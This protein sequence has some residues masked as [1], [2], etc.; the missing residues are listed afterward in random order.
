ML[1]ACARYAHADPRFEASGFVGVDYFS[2]KSQLG[3][4]QDP[5]QIPGTAPL[6]GARVGYLVFPGMLA[7]RLQLGVEGELGLATAYTGYARN[8]SGDSFFAPVF[9]WHAHAL[10]RLTGDSGL[11][12]TVRPHLVLG[13]GG[14]TVASSSP[15]MQKETDPVV[16]WGLGVTVPVMT[17]WQLRIDVR[18]G[19]MP[20]RGGSETS[21]FAVQFGVSTS[22]GLATRTI[23]GTRSEL[24]PQVAVH[25]EDTDGDGIPDRLDK[26][27]TARENING[28]EDEDGCPEPDPDG[29]GLVGA[30][31]KCP[32]QAEDFDGFQDEDGCPD[33]DNDSDGIPDTADACPNEPETRNGFQDDDGCPDV[34]PPEITTAMASATTVRF[35]GGRARITEPAKLALAPIVAM[36]VTYHNM[37]LAVV[38]HLERLHGEDLARR[39]AEAVKWYLVDQGFAE[40]R[41]EVR[42][43]AVQR[44]PPIHVELLVSAPPSH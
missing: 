9:E 23:P 31:D 24:P 39:R 26:C 8:G 13:G 32:D 11:L 34:V 28:V 30:D 35:E 40:D 3:N 37:R 43:G 18:E 6:L 5:S 20:A 2:N 22:F 10:L 21:T 29:D 41:L 42:V 16:Y 17:D 33:P 7:G 36:L 38:G 4:S 27:P 1:I 15:L 12:G 19:L 14:E 25:D 44:T